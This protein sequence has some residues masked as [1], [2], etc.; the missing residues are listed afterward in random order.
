MDARIASFLTEKARISEPIHITHQVIAAELGT[1][2]EVISRILE[3]F[4]ALGMLRVSRGTIQVLD[5][6]ALQARSVV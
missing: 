4:S 2:R 5:R 6:E 3:D 1:S